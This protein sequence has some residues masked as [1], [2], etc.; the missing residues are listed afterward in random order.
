MNGKGSTRRP[1]D[2]AEL[3]RR[4]QQIQWTGR[5]EARDRAKALQSAALS[6]RMA[7]QSKHN[8]KP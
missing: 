5:E 1:E 6:D 2:K 7:R 8:S 3:D 4:W